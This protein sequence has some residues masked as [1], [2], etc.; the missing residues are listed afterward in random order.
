MSSQI[1]S[2]INIIEQ[3]SKNVKELIKVK[4]N[5]KESESDKNNER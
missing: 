4:I 1:Y 5:E 3:N 2:S